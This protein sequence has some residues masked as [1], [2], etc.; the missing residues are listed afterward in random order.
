M[1]TSAQAAQQAAG[2][3]DQARAGAVEGGR[4]VGD[5]VEAIGRIDAV[6][7][8]IADITSVIEDIAFQT[9]LLALNAAVEAARAGDAGKGFAVVASE[10]RTLAQ[11]SSEAARGIA[12]LITESVEEVSSGVRLG[13]EAGQALERIVETSS[14]V[15]GTISE[16]SSA[17][18]EQAAGI[19][20]ISQAVSQ[21]DGATQQN[22]AQAEQSAASATM[23][24]QQITSLED[25]VSSFRVRDDR[26]MVRQALRRAS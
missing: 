16:I 20:E 9:N 19:D 13:K 6:S 14:S 8:R 12:K 2:L 1:K 15:A 17:T 24:A 22:A 3:A 26:R 10:V 25:L 21:L 11:R 4:I 5:A 18:A 23:L 7:R